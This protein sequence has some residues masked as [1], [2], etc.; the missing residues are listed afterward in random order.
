MTTD[1]MI[2]LYYRDKEAFYLRFEYQIDEIEVQGLSKQEDS[3][4][5]VRII[6]DL[7]SRPG[8]H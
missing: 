5:R 6:R 4:D 7:Y 2:S 8:T 1:E 3:N